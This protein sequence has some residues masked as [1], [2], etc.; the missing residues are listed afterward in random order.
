M[1][2]LAT[3]TAP[4]VPDAAVSRLVP[5]VTDLVRR[6]TGTDP[7]P[8]RSGAGDVRLSAPLSFPDGIGRGAVVVEVFRYGAAVRVDL[9]IEHNRV[10]AARDGGP[11]ESRCYLNDYV[12]SVT[13]PLDVTELPLEFVRK[14]VAGVSAARTAVERYRRRDTGW[15]RIAITTAM[16]VWTPQRVA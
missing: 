1:T 6:A 12:A 9:A 14:V 3:P 16:P 8:L 7:A 11:S 4:C 2:P 5:S 15:L 13:L 10:F